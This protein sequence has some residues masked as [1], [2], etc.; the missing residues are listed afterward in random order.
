MIEIGKVQRSRDR[1]RVALV[2]AGAE[3]QPRTRNGRRGSRRRSPPRGGPR[4][5]SPR[6]ARL[7]VI[8]RRGAGG[9]ACAAAPGTKASN[10]AQNWSRSASRSIRISC[11]R[12]LDDDDASRPGGSPRI[13]PRR[14]CR[15]PDPR[16]RR[17]SGSA[18]WRVGE[19]SGRRT[20]ASPGTPRAPSRWSG[21]R[22]R[23]AAPPRTRPAIRA[24]RV[25]VGREDVA[26][27]RTR[28][29]GLR[30]VAGREGAAEAEGV[31]DA[32]H[33]PGGAPMVD[34]LHRDHRRGEDEPIERAPAGLVDEK[35]DRRPHGMAEA[36]P[37]PRAMRLEDRRD[38]SVEIALEL[39]EVVDVALARVAQRPIR[40]ALA[41]PVEAPRPQNRARAGPSPPRNISRRTRPARRG[42]PPC[43]APRR[44]ASSARRAA[45]RRRPSG[46][47]PRPR[48]EARD[49]RLSTP[50]SSVAPIAAARP[51][52]PPHI[53]GFRPAPSR[54]S[55]DAGVRP[56]AASRRRPA[57]LRGRTHRPTVP[58]VIGDPAARPGHGN[59]VRASSRR[60]SAAAPATVSG[61]PFAQSKPLG[62]KALG[63][64]AKATT[65]EPG[66]RPTTS[67]T[68]RRRWDGRRTYGQVQTAVRL[69]PRRVLARGAPAD[70][71]SRP[72]DVDRA[73]RDHRHRR[74]RRRAGQRHRLRRH[75]HSRL[76]DP[77]MGRERHHRG[78]AR[79]RRRRPSPR[80]AARAR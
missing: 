32:D 67:S 21:R 19:N 61:E 42:S 36:E 28:P 22:G 30:A 71:R 24:N 78:P 25:G 60:N 73:R 44:P 33:V 4:R 65:R 27:E 39:R 68:N 1:E 23:G 74:P 76:P 63:R 62:P 69:R 77:A 49:C 34:P 7:V 18:C 14:R 29:E 3:E 8:E 80:T 48:R 52:G 70:S 11:S 6:G 75:R 66:D 43:P 10:A 13:A 47:P 57:R 72:S 45:E 64:R 9:A 26:F 54:R 59:A 38:K 31:E 5:P 2:D 37:G 53:S 35:Q 40:A 20:A 51:P 58:N 79:G 16:P 15:S 55:R 41:P 17:R 12:A 56:G 50:R 46:R